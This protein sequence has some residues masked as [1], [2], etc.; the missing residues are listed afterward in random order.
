MKNMI[1]YKNCLAVIVLL[2][3]CPLGVQ[4]QE[5]SNQQTG[6]SQ[7]AQASSQPDESVTSPEFREPAPA[8]EENAPVPPPA[9]IA[10]PSLGFTSDLERANYLRGGISL[11]TTYDDNV[12][13]T[14][15][16][17]VGG[18][19][20]SALP[21]LALDIS[22]NRLRWTSLY[23]AGLTVNQ[24]LS[25]QNQGSHNLGMDFEYRLSPHVTLS[26][27]DR[28]SLTTDFFDQVQTS[29]DLSGGG[30]LQQ[31]NATVVTPLAKS[32]GNNVNGQVSWQFGAG[33][34]LGM[35]GGY[36]NTSYDDVTP[37]TTSLLDTT[38]E[39]ASGFYSH[40]ITAR[41]WI[42]VRYGFQHMSFQPENEQTTSQSVML[43][44]TIYL[45]PTM[46]LSFFAGPEY[47]AVDS[48]I[49]IPQVQLPFVLFVSIPISQKRWS[50]AGG[51]SYSWQGE[52]TSI[53]AGVVRQVSD[54]GGV[55]GAVTLTSVS[56]ALRRQI[57]RST[58]LSFSG[59][60][61]T[62]DALFTS[63]SGI[64]SL[65]TATGSIGIGRRLGAHF[66][67][68][69]SYARIY[70]EPAAGATVSVPAYHNRGLV[71][72][73]YDFSRPLGR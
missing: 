42:G 43:F 59:G 72:F 56:G 25:S 62:N 2:S 4:A 46:Q 14:A 57:A 63:T 19:T 64:G 33:S 26:V 7:A 58:T 32:T 41:N 73:S 8:M 47:S 36:Y 45:K 49:V 6:Q 68:D 15:S 70:Q 1:N 48:Q 55:Q 23:S 31:P 30:I 27:T 18:F 40:R 5:A 71:T 51:A 44:H 52:H 24:R 35:T 66:G 20:Y 3:L 29:P 10:G 39:S 17:R 12:F 13:N 65:K 37:G 34:M 9:S 50:G 11:G 53:T 22:T 61:A 67:L 54:G 69:L 28:F 21:H 38:T 16:N 60:Y